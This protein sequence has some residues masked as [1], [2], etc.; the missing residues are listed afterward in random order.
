[1]ADENSPHETD[2]ESGVERDESENQT[3]NQPANKQ[4]KSCID[5]FWRFAEAHISPPIDENTV[6]GK[7]RKHCKE[8]IKFW[9]EICGFVG[10]VILAIIFGLQLYEMHE[11]TVA[12]QKQL[13]E[14]QTNMIVDERAWLSFDKPG[15]VLPYAPGHVVLRIYVLNSGKTPAMIDKIITEDFTSMEPFSTRKLVSVGT[16]RSLVAGPNQEYPLDLSN[17]NIGT[18]EF[19]LM[20]ERKVVHIFHF[21]IEYHDVFDG[22]HTNDEQFII[23]GPNADFGEGHVLIPLPG[24][25]MN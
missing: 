18:N 25:K 23:G 3:S 11:T 8:E 16:N 14:M 21:I 5:R 4:K 1:M 17:Y 9:L 2:C 12:A 15:M 19:D 20:A 7:I 22:K 13:S 24:A 6:A 10:G